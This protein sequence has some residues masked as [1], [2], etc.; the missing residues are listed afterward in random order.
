MRLLNRNKDILEH[1]IEYCNQISEAVNTFGS[2]Y[3]IFKSNNVYKN[4]VALCI[5]QIGELAGKLTDHF[6]E[7]YNDIPWQQI[8]AVRNIVAHSYGSIDSEI[9]W[10]IMNDDIPVLKE[11]CMRIL[12]SQ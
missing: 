7:Q 8:K 12:N 6:K 4:S 10:E 9:I 3:D 1:I 2:S 5:L 11:Y